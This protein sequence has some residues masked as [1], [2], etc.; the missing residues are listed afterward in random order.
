VRQQ[1]G[2]KSV[3]GSGGVDRS[4]ST[5]GCL[6]AEYSRRIEGAHTADIMQQGARIGVL[7]GTH[8][9][10]RAAAGILGKLEGVAVVSQF[11]ILSL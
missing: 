9:D 7:G 10:Q 11:E 6:G 2:T 8:G 4:C 3:G 1:I 5:R